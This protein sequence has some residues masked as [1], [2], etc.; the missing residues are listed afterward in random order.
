MSL[1]LKQLRLVGFKSIDNR[2]QTIE[3]SDDVTLLVGPNG[4][5]KS[6]VISFFAMLNTMM[7]N[8]LRQFVAEQGYAQSILHYGPEVTTKLAAELLFSGRDE[9]EPSVRQN[10]YR[11]SLT[12]AAGDTL[13]F[14]DETIEYQRLGNENQAPISTPYNLGVGHPES[15][16]KAARD[17]G[18]KTADVLYNLLQSCRVYQFHN[19]ASTAK[20]RG[21]GYINDSRYLRSDG[22]NLA[23][24]LFA[25]KENQDTYPYYAR[26]VRYIQQIMPQFGDFDLAPASGNNNYI[27]LDWH[28]QQTP[29]Y[30]FGPHQLSD[31]SLRFMALAALLLQPPTTLPSTIIIDEPELGL[32]P[33]ALTVFAAMVKIASQHSQV[34]LATQSARLVDEFNAE[35]IIIVERDNIQRSSLFR[36]LDTE[37]LQD[38]LNAYSL[39]ELWEK[40]V[41]GGLP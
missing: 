13:I 1:K 20:I 17:G 19:T 25:V 31:G 29:G 28:E 6:N 40:N 41:L 24:F 9:K 10:F 38:W 16:L 15:Q 30:L 5:G 3:F 12:H 18:Q 36:R 35:Q 34:I 8:A 26:I 21:Q 32:H 37:A 33:A 39:S 2:G 7:T 14:A 22:G 11:F 4:A 27:R 23:A